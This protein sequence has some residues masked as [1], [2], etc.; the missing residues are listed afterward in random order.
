M[1]RRQQYARQVR[2][3]FDCFFFLRISSRNVVCFDGG[4]EGKDCRFRILSIL[5]IEE[6]A[7][8]NSSGKKMRSRHVDGQKTRHR[9]VCLFHLRHR[10]PTTGHHDL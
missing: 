9:F 10:P 1:I 4:T 5:A 6:A 2:S 3:F 7:Q 8:R